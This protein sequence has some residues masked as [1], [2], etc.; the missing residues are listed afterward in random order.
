MKTMNN[1]RLIAALLEGGTFGATNCKSVVGPRGAYNL[2][3]NYQVNVIQFMCERIVK[4]TLESMRTEI[5]GILTV[6]KLICNIW[7][8]RCH[9]IMST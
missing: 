7:I 4:K 6:E 5:F 3:N 8:M 9:K 1:K 2:H